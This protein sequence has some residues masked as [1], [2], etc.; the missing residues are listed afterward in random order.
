MSTSISLQD[1]LSYSTGIM[2]GLIIAMAV[3]AI[4]YLIYLII[5]Y[6]PKPK[7]K[8]KTKPVPKITEDLATIKRRYLKLIEA[9]ELDLNNQKI[10]EREGYIR[11]SSVV[12]NFVHEATGLDTQNLTLN[13]IKELSMPSLYDLIERF[14][15]PEFALEK[16]DIIMETSVRD[17][18]RVVET[19]N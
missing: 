13:E 3:P 8:T 4:I 7:P 6:M 2:I 14:Y 1:P 11:L 18:R 15:R 19:W 12:R 5:K 16:G 9:V 10:D 17:A